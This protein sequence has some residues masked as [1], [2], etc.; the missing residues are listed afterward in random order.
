MTRTVTLPADLDEVRA[1][2]SRIAKTGVHGGNAHT[3]YELITLTLPALLTAAE[4]G[5]HLA[6]RIRAR[7][8]PHRH[9]GRGRRRCRECGFPFPCP[10]IE[11]LE[12]GPA[13]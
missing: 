3:A 1:A 5:Q 6:E 8:T 13:R 7:H 9:G 10:T 2:A 12:E 11:D 4:Q